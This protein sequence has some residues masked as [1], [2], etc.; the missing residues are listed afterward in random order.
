MGDEEPPS[1]FRTGGVSYLH[2]PCRDPS[3]AADFYE[4]V[5]G[6][7]PRRDSDEPA[8]SDATGHVIG[9]F[10][11]GEP[12]PA[13]TGILPFVYVENVDAI[14]GDVERHGGSVASS[15]RP[16]GSLRV[17]TFHDPEGNLMGLWTET[18]R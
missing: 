16:E 9:H 2:I 12:A 15:A 1:V 14:L 5:L 6:W 3:R 18:A 4:V 10:I 11:V 13:Q 7:R 17:A 8:F